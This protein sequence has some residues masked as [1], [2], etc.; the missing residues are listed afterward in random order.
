MSH[1]FKPFQDA[2]RA[3]GFRRESVSCRGTPNEVR[4]YVRVL[5]GLKVDV[6]LDGRRGGR[7]SHWHA[8]VDGER[9]RINEL[10]VSRGYTPGQG[11]G[12]MDTRPSTFTTVEG[13][14]AAVAW[15]ASRTALGVPRDRARDFC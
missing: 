8:L 13:M 3:A 9:A 4:I 12:V 5:H 10:L 2:L 15:E 1:N 7:V 6:Q 11:I 14:L